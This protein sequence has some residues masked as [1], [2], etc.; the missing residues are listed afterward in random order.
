MGQKWKIAKP[1]R[2]KEEYILIFTMKNFAKTS[3]EEEQILS[4]MPGPSQDLREVVS[5]E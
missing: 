3:K 5:T 4:N 1:E 2:E